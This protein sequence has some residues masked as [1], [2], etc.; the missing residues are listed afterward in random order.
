[1]PANFGE[2]I[3]LL[4]FLRNDLSV[5]VSDGISW[6]EQAN[7]APARSKS[8]NRLRSLCSTQPHIQGLFDKPLL[9]WGEPWCTGDPVSH[10][11]ESKNRV[12]TPSRLTQLR[13]KRNKSKKE[14]VWR[15]L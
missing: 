5:K 9:L 2:F 1:V 11:L 10:P 7:E 6:L 12:C 4:R 15:S 13:K 8:S 14:P 3:R